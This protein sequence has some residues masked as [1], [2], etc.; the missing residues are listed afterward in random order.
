MCAPS[1]FRHITELR[2]KIDFRIPALLLKHAAFA[3]NAS[4]VEFEMDV[5]VDLYSS[6]VE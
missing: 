1:D 6:G 3:D 4:N 5:R 2:I